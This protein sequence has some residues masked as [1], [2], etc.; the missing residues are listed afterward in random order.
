MPR[1]AR[2]APPPPPVEEYDHTDILSAEDFALFDFSD[3]LDPIYNETEYFKNPND[4]IKRRIN[5]LDLSEYTQAVAIKLL[6][7]YELPN[8]NDMDIE[9]V[10]LEELKAGEYQ[11]GRS[12]SDKQ[13]AGRIKALT[14]MLPSFEQYQNQDDI[15]WVIRKHRLLF[16]E[17]FENVIANNESASKIEAYLYA[18]KRVMS[19]ALTS[20]RHVL[21]GKYDALYVI[22]RDEVRQEEGNNKL[23]K[24]E[25]A[26]GGLIDWNVVLAKQKQ[27]EDNFNKLSEAQK[28]TIAGYTLNQDLLLLSL[29]TL[30]PPLR[31]EVKVLKF[32]TQ[33][34]LSR[35]ERKG[36]LILFENNDIFLELHE[37]KKRHGYIKI[38]LSDHLKKI[39][40]ESHQLY[41]RT[42]VFTQFKDRT[43]EAKA[44]T[45][46]IRLKNMFDGFKVGSSMLRSSYVTY[47]YAKRPR[48]NFNM[49]KWMAKMMRTSVTMLESAYHKILDDD[50][51]QPAQKPVAEKHKTYKPRGVPDEGDDDMEDENENEDDADGCAVLINRRT[52]K[53]N[54]NAYEKHKAAQKKYYEKKKDTILKKQ[55]ARR[56]A[57]PFKE[58]RRKVLYNLNHDSNYANHVRQETFQ[59]YDIKKLDNGRYI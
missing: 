33:G 25:L 12:N 9:D 39:I 6:A 52:F 3:P 4:N 17:L 36:D 35:Y 15:S 47:M 51:E 56:D 14:N 8:I 26:K 21:I 23:N 5:A 50:I 32:N 24:A 43:K 41:P 46:G 40:R 59:K 16:L 54:D 2:A 19:R 31:G 53:Q 57:N 7:N 44:G 37:V 29:Y 10:S 28:Q 49:K 42:H 34:Y 20:E 22:I 45:V 58:A 18:I 27:F 38:P 1:R 11:S 30:T 13:I 48:I 55:K